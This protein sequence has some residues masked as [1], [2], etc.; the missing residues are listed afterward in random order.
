[1]KNLLLS[2]F[3]ALNLNLLS[4]EEC[5]PSKWGA[6][7]EI[8]N[9][10]LMTPES[11][12]KASKLIKYGKTYSLGIIIDSNTPAYPPRS[13]SLQVVQPTQ[14]LSLIHISEPTRPY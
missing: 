14:Q 10:N 13:L 6:E 4:A 7:D 1:M 2:V 3:L 5:I 9:A 8:G 12:L 11:V